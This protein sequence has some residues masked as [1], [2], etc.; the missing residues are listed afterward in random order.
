MSRVILYH[1]ALP[2]RLAPGAVQAVLER[3]AYGKRVSLAPSREGREATLAGIA[4]ALAAAGEASGSRIAPESLRFSPDGKPWLAAAGAPAISIA[5]SGRHAVA[6]ASLDD[7]PGVDIE[8]AAESGLGA[9]RLRDW[10]AREA[11][12]KALGLGLRAAP[13][14]RVNAGP[15]G[16]ASCRGMTLRLLPLCLA[17]GIVGW[18]ATREPVAPLEIRELDV[19]AELRRVAAA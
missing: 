3:V 8:A 5:H 7:E 11:V 10:C 17:P 9:P 19:D 14:V 2:G 15:A 6:V 13:E 4:L 18:L 16:E 1:A 12:V